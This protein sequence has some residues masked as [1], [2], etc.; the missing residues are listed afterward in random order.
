MI[1]LG[2]DYGLRKAG[3]ALAVGPLAEPLRVIRAKTRSEL[4]EK[5]KDVV[6]AEEAEKVVVGVSEGEMASES[7]MFASELSQAIN[8]PVELQDET[9]STH[10]AQTRSMEAGIKRSKRKAMED[11]FAAAIILQN[12]LEK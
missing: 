11:A 12:Y 6:S 1:I 5:I 7:K 3:L 8:I 10:E 4:I 2:I 9:L